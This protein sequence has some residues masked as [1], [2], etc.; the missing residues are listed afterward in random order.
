MRIIRILLV[1]LLLPCCAA[2]T[3][4]ILFLITSCEL[5]S[6]GCMSMPVRALAAGLICWLLI[7][8]FLPA[9]VRMYV[10][11]HELT[12]AFWAAVLGRGISGIRISKQG[13][14]VKLTSSN[15]FIALAPYFFPFY[16]IIVILVYYI[17]QLFFELRGGYLLLPGLIGFTLGFHFSFTIYALSSPQKDV[18]QYGRLFSYVIIYLANMLVVGFFLVMISPAVS[19]KL[20]VASL[21][22]NLSTM[23]N[24][25][26][27]SCLK[28]IHS[29]NSVKKVLISSLNY[30][31]GSVGSSAHRMTRRVIPT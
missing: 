4:T 3:K 26:W 12:H 15:F 25:V 22:F 20:F 14:Y 18:Y 27:M 21:I 11:A 6:L 31:L 9:P 5:H 23:W 8:F 1:L 24:W 28:G 16:T 2:L 13:G 29:V 17:L 19:L 10:T 30:V 7:F